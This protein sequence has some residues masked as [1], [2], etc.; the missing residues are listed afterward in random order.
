MM[1]IRC[2]EAV[3]S[4][5]VTRLTRD[6]CKVS[7]H[8]GPYT[9]IDEVP[10]HVGG[11]VFGDH[12]DESHDGSD[13]NTFLVSPASW[14]EREDGKWNTYN[15]PRRNMDMMVILRSLETWSLTT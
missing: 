7:F 10:G 5:M 3:G 13:A 8:L 15:P 12:G 4:R 11:G 1:S 2:E 14:E 9:L 6:D